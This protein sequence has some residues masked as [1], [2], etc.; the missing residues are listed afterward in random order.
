VQRNTEVDR[1][2]KEQVKPQRYFLVNVLLLYFIVII[3]QFGFKLIY[4][5]LYPRCVH[6]EHVGVTH[7]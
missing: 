3:I 1:A 6:G 7:C 4:D 5:V 2:E